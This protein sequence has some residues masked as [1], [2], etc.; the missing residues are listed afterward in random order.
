MFES[1]NNISINGLKPKKKDSKSVQ[2]KKAIKNQFSKTL[3]SVDQNQNGRESP[4]SQMKTY[5]NG[6]FPSP[7]NNNSNN[8]N[9]SNNLKP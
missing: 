6:M 5:T 1:F 3:D 2:P 8:S 7:N 4:I 9:N